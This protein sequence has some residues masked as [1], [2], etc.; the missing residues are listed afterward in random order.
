MRSIW[1]GKGSVVFVRSIGDCACLKFGMTLCFVVRKSVRREQEVPQCF[2][3]CVVAM[4][5]V[6]KAKSEGEGHTLVR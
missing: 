6:E 4:H 1:G 3:H 5:C 2:M